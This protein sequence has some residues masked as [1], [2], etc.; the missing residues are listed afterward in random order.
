MTTSVKP[1]LTWTAPAGG[2]HGGYLNTPALKYTISRVTDGQLTKAGETTG[3]EFT[4]NDLDVTRQANVSYQVVAMSAAG[5]GAA[6]QSKAVN[7]GPQLA[8]PFA[9][10]FANKSYTTSPWMQ[11]TVKNADGATREPVWEPITSRTMEVDA[12]DDNPDGVTVTI[13]SQDTDQGLMQFT[14]TGQWTNYCESR[15]VMPAIDFSTMQNPVLTFYIFRESWSSLDRPHKM[16]VTTT[17][18]PWPHAATTASS[19]LLRASSTATADKTTGSFARF[20]SMP[21]PA[22]TAYRWHL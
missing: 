15:L 2:V 6:A 1:T 17:I 12:T 4:D 21:S 10:S 18:S 22:K 8:L 13:A 14:A 19:W 7:V 3:T 5:L 9:E 11:E 16:A 20:P